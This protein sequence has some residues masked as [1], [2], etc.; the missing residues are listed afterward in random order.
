MI[1][2]GI[3]SAAWPPKQSSGGPA[4]P[5]IPATIRLCAL[6]LFRLFLLTG[7][8]VLLTLLAG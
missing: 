2:H 5:A 3:P 7:I 4:W 6:A 1:L 8:R